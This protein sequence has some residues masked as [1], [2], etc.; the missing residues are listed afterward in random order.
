M[1]PPTIRTTRKM[2]QTIPA[3]KMPPTTSHDGKRNKRERRNATS[4][5]F[6]MICFFLTIQILFHMTR[7]LLMVFKN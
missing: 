2:P 5:S 7:R 6:F 4:V 1:I 3:L